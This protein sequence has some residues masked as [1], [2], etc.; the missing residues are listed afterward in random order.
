MLA[1]QTRYVGPTDTRGSR[2]VA[3]CEGKRATVPYDS[4]LEPEQNHRAAVIALC[5]KAGW[6]HMRFFGGCLRGGR[7]AWVPVFPYDWEKRHKEESHA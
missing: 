1:I 2:V 5:D 6:D 4:G 7:Y 3:S